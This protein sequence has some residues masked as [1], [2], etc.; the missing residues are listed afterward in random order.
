MLLA[1]SHLYVNGII[2]R[3]AGMC[4]SGRHP[5]SGVKDSPGKL[6]GKSHKVVEL[7]LS[8]LTFSTANC[9]CFN[10]TTGINELHNSDNKNFSDSCNNKFAS[11]LTAVVH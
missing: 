10:S 5:I 4:S 7:T 3:N 1:G 6:H 9:I 8:R 11:F 2:K